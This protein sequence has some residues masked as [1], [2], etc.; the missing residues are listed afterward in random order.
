[1]KTENRNLSKKVLSTQLKKSL[2]LAFCEAKKY[3]LKNVDSVF[4]LY[5]ILKTNDSLVIKNLGNIYRSSPILKNKIERSQ[6]KLRFELKKKSNH[7]YI[8]EDLEL[9]FTKFIRRI[10]ALIARS[11]KQKKTTVITTLH[12]FN[13]L[14]R[15]KSLKS[16]LKENLT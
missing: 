13:Y 8:S 5:S 10:L 1:M 9:N 16:W 4:L 12:V 11:P 14:V 6:K 15:N 7:T 2:Y 3:N